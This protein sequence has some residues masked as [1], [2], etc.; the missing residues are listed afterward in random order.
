[1]KE[2]LRPP[3]GTP[4]IGDQGGCSAFYT[5]DLLRKYPVLEVQGF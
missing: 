3:S 1:M 5:V 4:I 2:A